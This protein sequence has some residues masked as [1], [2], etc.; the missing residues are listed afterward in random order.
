MRST[1][2]SNGEGNVVGERSE[3]EIAE[4][5]KSI[6]GI[7]DATR[8]DSLSSQEIRRE[9]SSSSLLI[10]GVL[11]PSLMLDHV[12]NIGDVGN[13]STR[14]RKSLVDCFGE[15]LDVPLR[16]L[17]DVGDQITSVVGLQ[18]ITSIFPPLRAERTGVPPQ[19][20]PDR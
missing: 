9:R 16:I 4:I 7:S 8:N 1:N 11:L 2:F 15:E 3:V 18:I 17:L 20:P 13:I 19:H 6:S 10:L 5:R 14:F 12:E